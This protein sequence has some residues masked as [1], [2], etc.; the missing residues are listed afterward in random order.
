[1]FE[2]SIGKIKKSKELKLVYYQY[3]FESI[4]MEIKEHIKYWIDSAE[5][6]YQKINEMMIWLKSQIE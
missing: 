5:N 1:M 6:Y 4:H 3:E 2:Y